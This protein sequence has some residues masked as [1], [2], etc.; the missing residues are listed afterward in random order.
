[1]PLREDPTYHVGGLTK[2]ARRVRRWRGA[3][4]AHAARGAAVAYPDQVEALGVR[5]HTRWDRVSAPR[6]RVTAAAV[7]AKIRPLDFSTSVN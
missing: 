4:H 2:S 7:A 1:M 6:G 5:R 3:R